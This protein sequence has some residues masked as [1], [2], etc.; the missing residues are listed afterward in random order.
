[1]RLVV[2]GGAGYIGSVVAAMLLEAGHDVTVLDDLSTGH[3]DAVP[4]GARFVRASV[5]EAG[6]VFA[7]HRYDAVL[8][9]AA[10]SLVGESVDRPELYWRNNVVEGLALIEAMRI[11]GVPR[12]VFSSTAAVYGE[13]E[14][15]TIDELTPAVP[16][17]PY[18][19]SK[20]A[21]DFMLAGA[22]KAHGLAAVSLRYFNVGGAL[23]DHGERHRVETHLIPK[24]LAVATGAR[25]TV[26]VFGSDFPTED[27]SAV[28]DY[29]H[30][31][32][33]GRAHLLALEAARPSTHSVYNL[34]SGRGYSVLEVVEACRSVTGHD[35]PSVDAPRR[36][37]DPARLVASNE[38]I[39]ADLGWTPKASLHDIVADAWA[40]TQA[41]SRS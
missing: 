21:I 9:F 23:G 6:S 15:Q 27:G 14:V 26:S 28:R 18:G 19:H 35:I 38:R 31:V 11:H 29:V 1:M 20:L 30:V 7:D 4:A 24:V 12:M 34:G 17:N 10:K 37:G 33:L 13:P 40:F 41:R 39:A 16:I 5:A 36:P 3:E 2:T 25:P 22:A 8:H 32:D